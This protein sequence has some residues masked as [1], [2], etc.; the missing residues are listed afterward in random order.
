MAEDAE[1]QITLRGF[2]SAHSLLGDSFVFHQCKGSENHS[3]RLQYPSPM[4]RVVVST[5]L[6]EKEGGGFT[7]WAFVSLEA[8]ERGLL[9]GK[10][11]KI[12]N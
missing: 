5:E 7:S 3:R 6:I 11:R 9:I 4:K 1:G 12:L 2:I 10:R 8:L